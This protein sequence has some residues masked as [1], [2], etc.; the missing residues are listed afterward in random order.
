MHFDIKKIYGTN[1]VESKKHFLDH[2]LKEERNAACHFDCK[3]YI[4]R[5]SD[6]RAAFGKDCVQA[7]KH[8]KE[9]GIKEGRVGDCRFQCDCYLNK[10]EDLIASFGNNC[11]AALDHWI[12][13]GMK[14]GRTAWCSYETPAMGKKS[15]PKQNGC[16][17]SDSLKNLENDYVSKVVGSQQIEAWKGQAAV[18]EDGQSTGDASAQCG[19]RGCSDPKYA[20]NTQMATIDGKDSCSYSQCAMGTNTYLAGGAITKKPDVSSGCSYYHTGQFPYDPQ[21]C[22]ELTLNSPEQRED[23][24]IDSFGSGGYM[25]DTCRCITNTFCPSGKTETSCGNVGAWNN[26]DYYQGRKR[27]LQGSRRRP[28]P[29]PPP[30]PPK[31]LKEWLSAGTILN[32]NCCVYV[33]DIFN[34]TCYRNRYSDLKRAFGSNCGNATSGLEGHYRRHGINERRNAV[35]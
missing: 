32:G 15:T 27:S 4:G 29:R 17:T 25:T 23:C 11:A 3:C 5:H 35:C 18:F 34:C 1:Y 21:V 9:H 10:Y 19:Y 28:P 30:P 7:L 22:S 14:E 6:L 12:D 20:W 31:H 33:R 13:Y 24:R 2:G 8:W 16:V 26:R